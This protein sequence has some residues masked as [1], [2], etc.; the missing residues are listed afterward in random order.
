MDVVA[1][2]RNLLLAPKMEWPVIAAE[3]TSVETIYRGYVAWLAAIGPVATFFGTSLVGFGGVRIGLFSGL[4]FA[5]LSYAAS[6]V[7]VYVVALVV[8]RLAPSFDGTSDFLNAFKLV[9][10]SMTAAWLA[11]IF[12]VIPPL[13]IFGLLGLYSIYLLFTGVPVLMRAPQDK[14]LIYTI[15][16]IL[17][18]IVINFVVSAILSRLFSAPYLPAA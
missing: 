13:A 18:G 16:I 6:L 8:D 5:I 3:A 2:A 17:I 7:I 14:A 10:Y 1:R 4:L 15:A 12:A 11:G 9:A